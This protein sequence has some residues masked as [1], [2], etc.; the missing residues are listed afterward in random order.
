VGLGNYATRV[1]QYLRLQ[2]PGREVACGPGE[3]T[4]RWAKRPAGR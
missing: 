3:T 2:V 4:A 1:L